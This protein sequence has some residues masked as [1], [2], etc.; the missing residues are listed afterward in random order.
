MNVE[1][2]SIDRVRPYERN[3]RKNSTAVEKV[4]Q[5]LA[6]FGW[7]QPLVVD[8]QG[9]LIAG[10]TR[11]L[12][13]ASLG[14]LEVPVH[15][16]IS[17]SPE[18]VKAYRIADNRTGEEATWDNDRL[19]RELIELEIAGASLASTGFDDEELDKL[20]RR[21]GKLDE[22][23]DELPEAPVDPR[24]KLGDVI[25]MGRHRLV[26]GDSTAT[27]TIERVTG[28]D[29]VGAVVFDPTFERDDLIASIDLDQYGADD[30][31]V[32]G[33]CMNPTHRHV[34]TSKSWRFA[35]VWDGVT[36]WMVPGKPLLAHKT[37]DWF[38]S[39]SYDHDA[40]KDPRKVDTKPLKGKNSRGSYELEADPRGKS[41]ASV[42]RSPVTSESHGAEHSKPVIWLAMLLGNCTR[43]LVLDLFAGSGTTLLACEQIGRTW[44]G[45]EL[46]PAYCD[47][48]VARWE[49]ATGQQAV[50]ATAAAKS[51]TGKAA[52]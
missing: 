37:C 6:E 15:V 10:H 21:A 48:I 51:K 30:V 1:M 3:P 47:V 46:N 4:A 39:S 49:Q 14:W 40:V 24:T 27:A 52:A 38:G 41:L 11:L 9:V 34:K 42:F 36:R 23:G 50:Y 25:A 44:R 8:E 19:V 29:P 2:W 5:S 17:L 43:G 35:F 18:Q 13:A 32:F 16:A 22:T 33:D 45:V 20:L 28:G 31:L 7:R 12:A 26:C